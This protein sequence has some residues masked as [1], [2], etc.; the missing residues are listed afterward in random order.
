[1]AGQNIYFHLNH[2]IRWVRLVGVIVAFD[3]YPNRVTMTL[4]DSSGLTIEIFCRKETSNRTPVG[5]TVDCHGAISLNSE[6]RFLDDG[7]VYT[8]NEGYKVNLSGIDLGSI[9]KVKGGVGEYRG[10]K[11]VTLERICM[12]APPEGLLCLLMLASEAIIPT[13]NE[14]ASAWA[15]N[16]TFRER[17]LSKH[18][19]VDQRKQ[20]QAKIEAEGLA[21]E[22]EAR[23]E[24]KRKK[25]ELEEKREQKGKNNQGNSHQSNHQGTR[26]KQVAHRHGK[27][28]H[29]GRGQNE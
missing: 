10:T 7:Q 8:T 23:R 29:A 27:A 16:A 24:R 22:K 2:P 5:T 21:R 4:D 13:T 19:V 17:V 6:A 28:S 18:W 15:E 1:M 9:V 26:I 3:L 11:Q 20:Q 14:E 12:L 25:R